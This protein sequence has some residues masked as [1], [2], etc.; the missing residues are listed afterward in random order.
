MDQQ[1]SLQTPIN[2]VLISVESET[3]ERYYF[4]S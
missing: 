1:E 2:D 3:V 4:T